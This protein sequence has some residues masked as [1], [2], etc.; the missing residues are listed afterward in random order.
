M[1]IV[2]N[3]LLTIVLCGLIY[4]YAHKMRRDIKLRDYGKDIKA[5][6]LDCD[7][8]KDKYYA[9]IEYKIGKNVHTK[10]IYITK[11]KPIKI[12]DSVNL[13]YLPENPAIV[14]VNF[15][16]NRVAGSM[17]YFW[18]FVVFYFIIRTTKLMVDSCRPND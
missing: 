10:F 1:R 5:T 3:I 11:E 17:N 6:I 14:E 16:P 12:K 9:K 15:D 7:E 18:F 2:A 8:R 4:N 13:R